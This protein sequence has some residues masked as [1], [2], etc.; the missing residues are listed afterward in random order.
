MFV[1]AVEVPAGLLFGGGENGA[2]GRDEALQDGASR[3]VALGFLQARM[4][5][6]DQ[7]VHAVTLLW[8]RYAAS[9]L[10]AVV[11][12][13]TSGRLAAAEEI[14][15]LNVALRAADRAGGHDLASGYFA[16]LHEHVADV[17]QMPAQL[18]DLPEDVRGL[19][20]ARAGALTDAP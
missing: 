6:G 16:R 2:G 1:R 13:V 15:A 8:P 9:L 12:I 11:P 14:D 19:E 5:E 10:V 7:L 4:Q 3:G 17:L 18:L 20:P